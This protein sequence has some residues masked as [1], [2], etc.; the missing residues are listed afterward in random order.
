MCVTFSEYFTFQNFRFKKIKKKKNVFRFQIY[1]FSYFIEISCK[2][3]NVEFVTF[4]PS[5]P[6]SLIFKTNL[7]LEIHN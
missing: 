1:H 5:W 3:I 4:I 2:L 7:K 6:R